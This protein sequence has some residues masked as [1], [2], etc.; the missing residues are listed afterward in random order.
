MVDL[1]ERDG[2][3]ID[4]AVLQEELGVRVISTVA[5]R[6]RGLVELAEAIAS[7][8]TRHPGPG[9]TALGATE[10]RVAAHAMADAAILSESKRHRLHAK[11]DKVLLHPGSA[12]SS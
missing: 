12:S 11:L 7:A 4:P 8:E 2:L 1:A 9:L 10:R 6:R 3:V 5:V